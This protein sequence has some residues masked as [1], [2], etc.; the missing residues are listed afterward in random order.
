MI[1][2]QN[3]EKERFYLLDIARAV[4]AIC[5]VL[6]HYQHF[7]FVSGRNYPIDFVRD[8]QPFYELLKPFYLF[9]TVAVQFFFVLSGFIFFFMY[10]KKIYERKINIKNFFILRVSRL[11]PLHILT[12]ISAMALQIFYFNINGE[13][14]VNNINDYKHFIYHFF[15]V[16]EWG[17]A[18]GWAFNHPSW[19][20]SVE[21][22]LYVIF[23]IT[24]FIGINN[25]R[26]SLLA[27]I[28]SFVIF[29]FTLNYLEGVSLGLVCF[30]IGGAT[31]FISQIIKKILLKDNLIKTIVLLLLLL[32]NI[33]VFGRFLNS[34]FLEYQKSL[35]FL[36]G[37]NFYILLFL[38]KFPMIIL[39]LS[40]IQFYFK[41]LGK[42]FQLLGD[43]SYTIY[44]LHFVIQIIFSLIDK[45]LYEI[46]FDSNYIFIL[47]FTTLF[48]SS[49]FIYQ[50]IELKMKI[51]IRKKFI[52]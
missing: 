9:G 35:E 3:L 21:I 43:L 29:I 20:I 51:L 27:L 37:D 42:S 1:N 33:L 25:L 11:Y 22:L 13:Y 38:I 14:F 39:N 31:F 10:S 50:Y 17:F 2:N 26:S 5:V 16:Q 52:K 32:L 12:L 41:N 23:F 28:I 30:Y 44:L 40:L 48:I 7:Y 15:L 49:F 24:A 19:S 36:I 8:Q 47:F 46:N 45:S 18:E 6:Q 4:A 34:F